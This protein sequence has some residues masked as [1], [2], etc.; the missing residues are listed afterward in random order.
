M[1]QVDVTINGRHYQIA[2]DEGQEAHLAQL[3]SYVDDRV[4]ELVAAIGQVGDARLLVMTSLLVAD[5]LSEAYATLTEA[6]LGPRTDGLGPISIGDREDAIA[7][8]IEQMA[9]RIE[10]IAAGLERP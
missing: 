10:S 9:E 2:C 5:E 1:P 6:G 8:R 4:Q 3:A 7:A